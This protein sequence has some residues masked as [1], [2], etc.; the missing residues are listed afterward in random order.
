MSRAKECS[1][2]YVVAD[3]L[4]QATED[5]RREWGTERR[6][7]WVIDTGTPVSDPLEAEV[8]RAVARPMRDALRHGRLVAERDAILAVVPANPTAEIRAAELQRSRLDAE[9][10][11]LA[12][13]TGRYRDHPVRQALGELRLAESNVARLQRNL[14]GCRSRKERKAW[15]ADL[16]EW[17]RKLAAAARDLAEVSDPEL[18]RLDKEEQGLQRRLTGLWSRREKYESWAA[19]HP[20]AERRLEHLN[21]EI[22]PLDQ[23]LDRKGPG[24]DLPQSLQPERWAELAHSQDRSLGLDLGL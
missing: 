19:R 18:T 8:S 23:I 1:T 10:E 16:E 11:H 20:E 7:G 3:S 13:G 17:R 22:G 21:A 12:K 9:R 2:V 15:E 4:N 5:L 14:A 6:L 24:R